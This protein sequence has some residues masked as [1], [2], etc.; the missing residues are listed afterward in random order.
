MQ[1]VVNSYCYELLW[2][3]IRSA[4][5]M[6][7]TVPPHLI[8]AHPSWA[9]IPPCILHHPETSPSSH[10]PH[11]LQLLLVDLDSIYRRTHSTY[12]GSGMSWVFSKHQHPFPF[13]P[14]SLLEQKF[15]FLLQVLKFWVNGR[16]FNKSQRM[17][18]RNERWEPAL[19]S[20]E[21]VNLLNAG[22]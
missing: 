4:I 10:L 9:H 20:T 18:S 13:F 5:S 22:D 3:V 21:G 7:F 2:P 15:P 14:L 17:M 8:A 12:S 1:H 6:A 11:I 19:F 16:S